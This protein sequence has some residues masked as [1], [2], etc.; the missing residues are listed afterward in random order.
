MAFLVLL[1]YARTSSKNA[2][3]AAGNAFTRPMYSSVFL[4]LKHAKNKHGSIAISQVLNWLKRWKVSPFR[5]LPSNFMSRSF[6]SKNPL[7]VNRQI[8]QDALVYSHNND[9]FY[10]ALSYF[11]IFQLSLWGYLAFS[12]QDLRLP[13]IRDVNDPPLWKRFLYKEGQYKNALSLLSLIV[14]ASIF[15]ITLTYPRRAVKNLWMLKGGQ[16]V[17]I[18][19]YSWLGKEKTFKKPIEHINCLQSRTGAGQHIPL[20][21]KGSSFYFLLDK[22]GSFHNTDLFDFLIAVKR[23]IK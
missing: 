15:F 3:S 16:E 9:S 4:N 20:Q 2:V 7:D 10:K 11:G 22:K 6:A 23:N 1:G 13:T 17:Q 8:L 18:T 19:T 12:I 14:G 21:V 5:G